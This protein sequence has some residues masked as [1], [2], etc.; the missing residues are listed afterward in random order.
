MSSWRDWSSN[1]TY[2][3]WCEDLFRQKLSDA[4]FDLRY[5]QILACNARLHQLCLK[6]C[7]QV[8]KISSANFFFYDANESLYLFDRFNHH[9]IFDRVRA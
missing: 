3:C 2:F 5:R 8:D 6:H 9:H 1:L 4:N 7:G